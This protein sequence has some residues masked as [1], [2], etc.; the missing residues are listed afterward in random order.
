MVIY[1]YLRSKRRVPPRRGRGNEMAD[2]IGEAVPARLSLD[3]IK[4][5]GMRAFFEEHSGE[6]I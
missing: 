5:D 6:E 3:E 2:T 4:D 1:G